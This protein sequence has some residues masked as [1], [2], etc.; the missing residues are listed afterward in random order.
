[1]ARS[2]RLPR[3]SALGRRPL[4][5]ESTRARRL[6]HRLRTAR[7]SVLGS[8]ADALVHLQT[9][10]ALLAQQHSRGAVSPVAVYDPISLWSTGGAADCRSDHST[11]V[12]LVCRGS[13]AAAARRSGGRFNQ[14]KSKLLPCLSTAKLFARS[15]GDVS[16]GRARCGCDTR[17]H[18][19]A[20]AG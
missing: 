12:D 10:P 18:S 7:P 20:L 11:I 3:R 5:H 15:D 16:A 17:Q 13:V 1:M 4:V 9:I 2:E 8:E 19:V 6:P 14:A